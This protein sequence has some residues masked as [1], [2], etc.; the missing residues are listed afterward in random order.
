MKGLVWQFWVGGGHNQDIDAAN[1]C[2]NEVA[3]QG[4][5]TWGWAYKLEA[6]QFN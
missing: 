4:V 2:L 3:G 5:G 1:V 6:K